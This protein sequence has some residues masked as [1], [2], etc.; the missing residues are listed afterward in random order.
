MIKY[1]FLTFIVFYLSYFLYES[2]Y[3]KDKFNNDLS[4]NGF[5]IID[6]DPLNYLP[7]GYILLDYKFILNCSTISS[8]HRDIFTSKYNL[9]AKYP[10]YTYLIYM[11]KKNGT[12]PLL[13]VCPSS[14]LSVPFLWSR[15]VTIYGEYNT[16]ILFDSDLIHAGAINDLGKNR[17]AEQYKI[18][19]KDDAYLLD[20]IVGTNRLV[21]CK[22]T[23]DK[24]YDK[25]VISGSL[26]FSYP[27]N[28]VFGKYIE[29][30]NKNIFGTIISK[31]LGNDYIY[32]NNDNNDEM[33][34]K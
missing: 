9:N 7:D 14:H 2:K 31:I 18:V 28:H 11:N 21:E 34:L 27:I 25:I 1:I 3:E 24:W 10:I 29:V 5:I 20:N 12:H 33:P 8:F 13:S 17:Y 30:T 15:P 4:K 32:D 26:L 22:I 6:N 23:G 16:S 19:H